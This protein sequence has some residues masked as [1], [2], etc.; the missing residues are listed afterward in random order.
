VI[1]YLQ[2]MWALA[3]AG[4]KQGVFFYA[5]LYLLLL[6][7]WSAVFQLRVRGWPAT[8]GTLISAEVERFG[9]TTRAPS[10]QDYVGKASYRYSIDGVEYAGH[11]IS[12]WAIVASHNARFVLDWQ[13]GGATGGENRS[14]SVIYKPSDPGRSY[15]LRPGW[16]GITLTLAGAFLPMAFYAV[17]YSG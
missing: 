3:V 4:Q 7:S 9:A 13:L 10:D 5:S 12:P 16:F 11:R 1:E 14:V 8:D 2:A 6:L 17:I 15:L